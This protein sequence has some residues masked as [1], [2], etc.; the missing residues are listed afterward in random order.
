MFRC[1]WRIIAFKLLARHR[2]RILIL[3]ESL[4]FPLHW[5]T[6]YEYV[7]RILYTNYVTYPTL[8]WLQ[9]L[10]AKVPKTSPAKPKV[11]W[12]ALRR[13]LGS[14]SAT[15]LEKG[16]GN[17]DRQLLRMKE[18]LNKRKL[19]EQKGLR[20]TRSTCSAQTNPVGQQ[21]GEWDHNSIIKEMF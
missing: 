8:H 13:G 17:L 19:D 21:E 10:Q 7:Y 3:T 20:I 18:A 11:R 16:K 14:C 6:L 9:A 1:A 12:Q 5:W 15:G 2:L 4:D